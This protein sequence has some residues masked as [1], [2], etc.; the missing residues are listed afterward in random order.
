MVG[1]ILCPLMNTIDWQC[2]HV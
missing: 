2:H 1:R